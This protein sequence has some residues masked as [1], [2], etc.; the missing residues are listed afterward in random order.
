LRFILGM[1]Q[2]QGLSL[3]LRAQALLPFGL[4][5]FREIDAIAAAKQSVSQLHLDGQI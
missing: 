2:A 1:G 4:A 3:I 5:V